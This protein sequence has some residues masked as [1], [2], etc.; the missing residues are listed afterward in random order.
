MRRGID[1]DDEEDALVSPLAGLSFNGEHVWLDDMHISTWDCPSCLLGEDGDCQVCEFFSPEE[2]PLVRNPTLCDDLAMLFSM[3]RESRRLLAEQW[4]EKERL[5]G[6]LVRALQSELLT[7]GRPLH[8]S[9]VAQIISDRHP[10]LSATE[11]AIVKVLAQH[12]EMFNRLEAGV[13]E[14]RYEAHP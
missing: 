10:D 2:C 14:A 13:Y 9:V 7:H 8:Y 6:R 4:E 11:T 1:D 5:N 12:P 3:N